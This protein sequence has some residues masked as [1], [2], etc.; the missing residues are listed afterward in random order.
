MGNKVY[1]KGSYVDIHDNKVVNLNIDRA[2]RV[3]VSGAVALATGKGSAAATQEVAKPEMLAT[4]EATVLWKRLHAAALCDEEGRLSEGMTKQDAMYVALLMG[5]RLWQE[6]RWKPF[7]QW[8]GMQHLAQELVRMRD[9]GRMPR[10]AKDIERAL[11][12]VKN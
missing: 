10:H 12:E 2:G 7:E 8:W 1:V 9:T 3:N 11:G 4:A 6:T 5:E